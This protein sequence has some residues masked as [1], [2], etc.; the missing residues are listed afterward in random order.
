MPADDTIK[1]AVIAALKKEGWTIT[2]DP[3]TLEFGDLYL[4]IDLGATR[5]I[6]AERDNEKIAVEI[7]S[8]PGKSKVAELQQAVGQYV[9]Y[10][11]ILRRV[12]PDRKLYL[13]VSKDIHNRILVPISG[14]VVVSDEGIQLV[15]VDVTVEEIVLWVT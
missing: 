10:R 6:I 13:A 3:L 9:V 1:S 14:Q 5:T 7:K 8:F 4:F 15:V 2:N 11:A 12:E